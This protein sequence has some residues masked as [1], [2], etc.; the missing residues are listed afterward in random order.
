VKSILNYGV[1]YRDQTF[2]K[3]DLRLINRALVI[4]NVLLRLL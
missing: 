4:V 1:K 3:V 2:F